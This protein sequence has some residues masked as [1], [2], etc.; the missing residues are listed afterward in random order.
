MR[1][2]SSTRSE[3]NRCGAPALDVYVSLS[4]TV[5]AHV[6]LSLPH[7]GKLAQMKLETTGVFALECVFNL[8]TDRRFS[9]RSDRLDHSENF[10]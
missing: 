1:V 3:E 2:E 7:R 4:I 6:Q 5:L 10:V 8:C 9:E